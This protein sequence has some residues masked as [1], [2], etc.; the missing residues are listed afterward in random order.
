M[1]KAKQD[2]NF[3]IQ[4]LAG[5]DTKAFFERFYKNHRTLIS[6]FQINR[7]LGRT[8]HCLPQRLRS[9]FFENFSSG[10]SPKETHSEEKNFQKTLILVFYVILQPPKHT[11]EIG[12]FSTFLRIVHWA[13]KNIFFAPNSK[14]TYRYMKINQ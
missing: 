14:Q 3:R 12:F 7:A 9:M 6:A 10:G 8:M 2:T 1:A 13:V 11:F 4:M 5:K